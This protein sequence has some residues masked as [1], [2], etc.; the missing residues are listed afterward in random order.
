MGFVFVQE[1]TPERWA[2]FARLRF[3]GFTPRWAMFWA[4][5]YE[6][7]IAATQVVESIER[8]EQVNHESSHV[9]RAPGSLGSCTLLPQ[10][11]IDLLEE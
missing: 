1:L 10:D 2:L 11:L 6:D 7:T 4:A 3:M 9:Y 8:R 5:R